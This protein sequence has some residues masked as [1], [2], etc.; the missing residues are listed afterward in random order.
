VDDILSK[1]E[2]TQDFLGIQSAAAT[3][4]PAHRVVG[5]A[6]RRTKEHL[7]A[8]DAGNDAGP[9]NLREVKTIK[10]NTD[11]SYLKTAEGRRVAGVKAALQYNG[12]PPPAVE[13]LLQNHL[14]IYTNK[15]SST[16]TNFRLQLPN[17]S[18]ATSYNDIDANPFPGEKII[19]KSQRKCHIHHCTRPFTHNGRCNRAPSIQCVFEGTANEKTSPASNQP[20]AT[21]TA[22]DDGEG[23]D[24]RN[25]AQN[26]DYLQAKLTYLT[27][28]VRAALYYAG[29]PPEMLEQMMKDKFRVAQHYNQKA[30]KY[31][32]SLT[33][34]NGKLAH[35][36]SQ[37]IENPYPGGKVTVDPICH[38]LGC[39]RRFG[40]KGNCAG[41]ASHHRRSKPEPTFDPGPMSSPPPP[42]KR[43]GAYSPFPLSNLPPQTKQ[44]L[45]LAPTPQQIEL[46][47]TKK[48]ES[49]LKVLVQAGYPT[50]VAEKLLENT[51]FKTSG[52]DKRGNILLKF[53]MKLP[54]GSSAGNE[55]TI[56][57]N[58]Y[59]LIGGGLFGG[60][61]YLPGFVQKQQKKQVQ[62][63]KTS[64]EESSLIS[65]SSS[66]SS[67]SSDEEGG[68]ESES[69][70]EED[71]GSHAKTPFMYL[72]TTEEE[73]NVDFQE[74][75]NHSNED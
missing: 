18:I 1:E 16:H 30:G 12:Y 10:Q 63:E 68:E 13:D 73:D 56:M 38:M 74:E 57:L 34:P 62:K 53:H 45:F 6:A 4:P 37:I 21:L 72:L 22:V 65:T 41:V 71:E 47:I 43:S 64:E 46:A 70:K 50:A 66:S 31:F 3:V 11:D 55:S 35:A 40:H 29:Y 5:R 44:K 15:N 28:G 48:K 42:G 7:Q 39:G 60:G 9:S 24:G 58:P 61:H 36:Y 8:A 59:S 33:L 49:L 67:S 54:N 26:L 75:D 17:G 2:P 51:I 14:R 20:I 25:N 32:W 23:P 69:D 19:E 27:A 52:L